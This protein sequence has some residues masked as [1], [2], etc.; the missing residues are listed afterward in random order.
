[1]NKT[2]TLT[3]FTP[4]YNCQEYIQETIDSVLNQTFTDFEYLIVD[5]CSTDNTVE[6]IEQYSDPRIRLIKNETNKGIS[7]NRNI[8]IEES[9]GIYLAMLDGDDIALPTRLEKQVLFLERNNDFGIVGTGVINMDSKGIALEDDIQ[10]NIPDE[11]IPSRMLFNNYVYT[12]SV[13]LR[14]AFIGELRFSLD[15]IVAEDYELWIQLI[16]KCNIGHVRE[17][18]IKYRIHD[19]SISNQK[20]QLMTDTEVS[21]IN[22]QLK[23]LNCSLNENE[24]KTFYA[25][26]KEEF[27]AYFDKFHE[28]DNLISKLN[29]ANNKT[30]IFDKKHFRKLLY[31]Y[32]RIFFVD[33]KKYKPGYF[34]SSLENGMFSLLSTK[35]KL[36]FIIKCFSFYTLRGKNND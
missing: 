11:Q 22:K 4:V 6:L 34:F 2:P 5:D 1:M 14:K 33:I 20:K 30:L 28:I 29:T 26:S 9:K 18:L 15:Y 7:Y 10:F 19:S 24:F 31:R 27:E 8:G 36:F 17:K 32:W 21:I 16:R 25:L 13:M 35:E 12:S 23:E 3:V